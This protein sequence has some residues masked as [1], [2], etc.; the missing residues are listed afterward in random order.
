MKVIAMGYTATGSSALVHLLKEYSNC[1]DV[2]SKNYEHNILYVPN[3]MF[4][5]EDVLLNN[6]SMYRS[7]AALNAF[8][9][10]MKNLNDNDYDWFGGYK[11]RFGN[12][13][14]EIVD[15]FISSLIIYSRDGGWS[16]DHQFKFSVGNVIK[17]IA[18]KCIGKDVKRFGYRIDIKGHDNITN[19]SFPTE[20]EF[21][22]AGRK[23]IDNYFEMVGY[24]KNRIYVFD[25]FIEPW[26]LYRIN[27]YFDD[28]I[29][30]V[31]FDRD[32]RDTFLLHK[33]IWS[34]SHPYY[35]MPN[36][37]KEFVDFY[38]RMYEMEKWIDDP[39]ILRVRFEDLIYNYSDSVNM[40]EQFIG[41]ELLG[42]HKYQKEF[43]N[44]DISIKNTQLFTI[45]GKWNEEVSTMIDSELSKHIY[46]FPYQH[47]TT[48]DDVTDPNP[49]TS[50]KA[51]IVGD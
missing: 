16:Y 15:E 42:E 28:D 43:F 12:R 32:P 25:Q 48:L 49:D 38:S 5:L 14:M 20:E 19:Y 13:F 22:R 4:D 50:K 8:Y 27:R 51:N 41:K 36:D 34:Q 7:D 35:L 9:K 47:K 26:Q 29:R 24:K 31:V 18:K 1:Y 45:D 2:D 44:P 33:Y 40:I 3:G 46:D 37:V 17:D 10:E 39:R 11:K 21:Y 30:F 6:N 23:F